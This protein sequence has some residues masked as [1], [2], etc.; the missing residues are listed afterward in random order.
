MIL[1]VDHRD[2]FTRNLVAEL[3]QRG[4][5]VTVR[6]F[7]EVP[8]KHHAEWLADATAVVLSPGPGHPD[9]YPRS[10][11]LCRNLP[12]GMPLLGVCLGLQLALRADGFS[13]ERIPRRP[14]HGRRVRIEPAVPSRW[15]SGFHHQGEFVLYNSLGCLHTCA[16]WDVLVRDTD[17][18][19]LVVEHRSEPRLLVQF[20]PESFASPGGSALFDALRTRL[21]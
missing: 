19:A 14:V 9:D 8:E 7:T 17:G 18:T 2:S 21:G 3:E 6:D 20:H 4:L 5:A 16:P 15:L 12:T 13:I 10:L 11:Q 1:L